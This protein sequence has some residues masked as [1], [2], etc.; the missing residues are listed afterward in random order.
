MT[1]S[2]LPS[3][4][5]DEIFHHL[6]HDRSSLLACSLTSRVLVLPARR[7]LFWHITLPLSKTD[8]MMRLL[9]DEHCTIATALRGLTLTDRTQSQIPSK[10]ESPKET[11]IST[12]KVQLASLQVIRL[13]YIYEDCIPSVIWDL[14]EGLPGVRE[15]QVDQVYWRNSPRL[16]SLLSS[17]PV[18][19]RFAITSCH[20]SG[21]NLSLPPPPCVR[22]RL[23]VP[24]LEIGPS[25]QKDILHW[26][27]AHGR[28]LTLHVLS[29]NLA[30][31]VETAR[32]VGSLLDMVAPT[33]RE[34]QLS[35]GNGILG[36]KL[37]LQ[38]YMFIYMYSF[39]IDSQVLDI[40]KFNACS[41]LRSLTI[42]TRYDPPRNTNVNLCI[43]SVFPQLLGVKSLRTL[44]WMVYVD[45]KKSRL[46]LVGFSEQV[47]YDEFN[48]PL[49]SQELRS[50]IGAQLN[51]LRICIEHYPVQF[52]EQTERYLRS[53]CF[54]EMDG[55]GKLQVI[56]H[57]P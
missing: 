25:A 21:L 4:T 42:V 5:L 27:A 26:L 56:F 11:D 1:F 6:H 18:F 23:L 35:L 16:F 17:M 24:V 45:K 34:L 13:E 47:L 38:S 40:V 36:E 10:S 33:L 28:S 44:S 37:V 32:L 3:E 12:V 48:W 43:R 57:A 50:S 41:N 53:E 49:L 14:L 22:N 15:V 51:R 29:L 20:W 19:E 55:K 2:K 39:F 46:P 54:P 8:I 7:L 31:N 52:H 30:I 9:S